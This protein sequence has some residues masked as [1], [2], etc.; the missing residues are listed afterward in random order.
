MFHRRNDGKPH[1]PD[2]MTDQK[3]QHIRALQ[4]NVESCQEQLTAM[5][6][7]MDKAFTRRGKV[8]LDGIT[9]NAFQDIM[10]GT[11]DK[12][13]EVRQEMAGYAKLAEELAAELDDDDRAYL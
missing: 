9:S 12:M 2:P 6:T 5:Q 8:G 10:A 1:H 3:I 7:A 11:R 13:P 4:V